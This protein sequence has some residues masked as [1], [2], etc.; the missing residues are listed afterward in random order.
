MAT[1]VIKRDGC[2]VP[3]DARRIEAAVRA[4]AQ[5]AQVD[6]LAW[7]TTVAQQVSAQL[8]TQAEVDIRDIQCAVEEAL[9]SGRWPQLAR[10]YIEYR[11]DRDLAREQRGKL[12]HAIRGLVEQTNAALLNENAN[13]DSKVIPTQ[14][15]LLAGIVAKHYAQQ[16]LLEAA[17]D[18]VDRHA[19]ALEQR[20]EVQHQPVDALRD[21]GIERHPGL[22]ERIEQAEVF[23]LRRGA[24]E[25]IGT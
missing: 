3:F 21:P 24:A 22:V 25:P 8:A 20:A 12:H 9:M 15:D 2:R 17:Q 23:R 10:A 19:D 7:C 18:H 5:A 1:V 6:D 4:A 16:Q 14:R 13:K 11:H